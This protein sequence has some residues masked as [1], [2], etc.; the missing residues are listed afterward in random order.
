MKKTKNEKTDQLHFHLSLC[1]QGPLQKQRGGGISLH[2]L[3]L[4]PYAAALPAAARISTSIK[5]NSNTSNSRR[6]DFHGVFVFSN[7][8]D[9]KGNIA[10]SKKQKQHCFLPSTLLILLAGRPP[11]CGNKFWRSPW[12]HRKENRAVTDYS[13]ADAIPSVDRRFGGGAIG[14]RKLD[15]FFLVV[16]I[17]PK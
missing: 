16:P 2:P 1:K 13:N 6:L 9:G 14:E 5:R 4:F 3:S 10:S 7:D 17:L 12:R 11:C 15:L 8:G